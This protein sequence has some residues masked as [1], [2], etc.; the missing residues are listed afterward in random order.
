MDE[1]KAALAA[2][3]EKE[4]EAKEEAGEVEEESPIKFWSPGDF[5]ERVTIIGG[6]PAGLAAAIYAA[7]AGLRPVIVAPPMGGQLQG[8]GV[9]VENY[10]GLSG[11]T[12]P[13]I[14]YDMIKQAAEFGTTFAQEMALSVEVRDER[15]RFKISTDQNNTIETHTIIVATGADSRWLGV[16]GEEQYRGGGVSSCATCDGFL[17]KDQE[18]AVIGGGDTAM[19][20]ALVCVYSKRKL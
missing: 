10:P 16:E 4:A 9:M 12:G 8:K 20:D 17:Y 13:T 18:V 3:E 19:E 1:L 2:L 15:P 6:G 14:V 7:R 5:P 11:L